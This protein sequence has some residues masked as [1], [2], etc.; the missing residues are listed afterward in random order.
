MKSSTAALMA[1]SANIEQCNLT[2]GKLRYDDISV[3][4]IFRASS[5]DF[6]L[7]NSVAYDDEAI[8]E[9]QPKV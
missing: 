6:P 2:G 3:F 5:K 7:I 1:S 4:F 9:P 8:A